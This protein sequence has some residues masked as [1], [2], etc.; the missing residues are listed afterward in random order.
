[1]TQE[2]VFALFRFN[3]MYAR[4]IKVSQYRIFSNRS[5]GFC[6]F[7][8]CLV[9]LLLVFEGGFYLPRISVCNSSYSTV[10]K[11]FHDSGYYVIMGFFAI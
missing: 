7:L 8:Y 4:L 5:R 1:M 3:S 10:Q 11:L 2:T 6:L 9:P